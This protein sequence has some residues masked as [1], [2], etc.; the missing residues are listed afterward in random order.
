MHTLDARCVPGHRPVPVQLRRHAVLGRQQRTRAL[1]A[2]DPASMAAAQTDFDGFEAYVLGLQRS[3]I[4]RA[5][6]LDGSGATFLEDRWQRN[7][8]NPGAGKC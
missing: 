7:S 3:I 8:A 6:Q 1:L 4:T 2:S 5:E